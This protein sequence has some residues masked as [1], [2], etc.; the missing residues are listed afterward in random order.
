ML[1]TQHVINPNRVALASDLAGAYPIGLSVDRFLDLF[2]DA[3]T[4]RVEAVA[5]TDTT[6]GQIIA[7][8]N[9]NDA[10]DALDNFDFGTS[11]SFQG[12]SRREVVRLGALTATGGAPTLS[13]T[14]SSLVDY[15]VHNLAGGGGYLT[16]DFGRTLTYAGLLYPRFEVVFGN[17]LGNLVGGIPVGALGFESYGE[18]PIYGGAIVDGL[19]QGFAIGSI[20]LSERYSAL[21]LSSTAASVG[22]TLTLTSSLSNPNAFASY[23]EAYFGPAKASISTVGKISTVIVPAHARSG[24]VRIESDAPRFDSFLTYGEVR[25]S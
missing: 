3:K 8:S 24:P 9:F 1:F 7:P 11:A 25:I 4:F 12:S 5:I 15:P 6:L 10:I 16:I 19:T 13:R 20:S 17:G 18:I 2:A 14:P 22:G 23:S 21:R